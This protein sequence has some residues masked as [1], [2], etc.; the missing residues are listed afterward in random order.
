MHP[1]EYTDDVLYDIFDLIIGYKETDK[2]RKNIHFP[3]WL[4]LLTQLK[5][6]YYYNKDDNVLTYIEDQHRININKPKTM[7][8]TLI[9]T[10]DNGGQRTLISDEVEKYGKV[11]YPSAFRKNTDSIPN[12]DWW[13]RDK[14]NYQS[15]LTS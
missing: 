1:R 9:A 8:C 10:H 12:I 14:V 15:R 7:F 4:Y 6:H 5:K 11:Y 3:Q 13:W 2:S